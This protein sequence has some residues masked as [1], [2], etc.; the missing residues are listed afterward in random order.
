MVFASR[1]L[2]KKQLTL[3]ISDHHRERA[4]TSPQTMRVELGHDAKFTIQLVDENN[5]IVGRIGT[6]ADA[7]TTPSP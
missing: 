1:A 2:L 3:R 5:P 4:V 7:I 6:Q